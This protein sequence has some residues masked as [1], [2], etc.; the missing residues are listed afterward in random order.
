MVVKVRGGDHSKDI[1]EYD[2]TRE[3]LRV[4]VRLTG[5]RGLVTGVP[6]SLAPKVREGDPSPDM[7]DREE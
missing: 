3:G 1:C 4:G 2:V 7:T 6:E 5:Y